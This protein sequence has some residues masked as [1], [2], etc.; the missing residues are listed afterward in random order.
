MESGIRPSQVTIRISKCTFII[1]IIIKSFSLWGKLGLYST[2]IVIIFYL[3]N[4]YYNICCKSKKSSSGE[5]ML[6]TM[7]ITRDDRR[8]HTHRNRSYRKRLGNEIDD[9]TYSK[10]SWEIPFKDVLAQNFTRT[11]FSVLFFSIMARIRKGN[12]MPKKIGVT[13]YPTKIFAHQYIL[14]SFDSVRALEIHDMARTCLMNSVRARD[15]RE[16]P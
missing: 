10:S 3:N 1:I 4:I 6:F 15:G 2:F 16:R 12:D 14:L 9:W 7:H 11:D 8:K 13:E 5:L